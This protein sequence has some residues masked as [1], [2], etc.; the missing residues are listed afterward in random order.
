MQLPINANG[1]FLPC[2]NGIFSLASHTRIFSLSPDSATQERKSFIGLSILPKKSYFQ[3]ESDVRV[4]FLLAV[5][6]DSLIYLILEFEASFT[7]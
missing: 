2:I 4:L 7:G 3:S 1:L 6:K 5:V